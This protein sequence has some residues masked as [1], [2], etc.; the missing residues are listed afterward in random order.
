V[1][2]GVVEVFVELWVRWD[3]VLFPATPSLELQ[4]ALVLPKDVQAEFSFH[5]FPGS[6][7]DFS[8]AV[9]KSCVEK[10]VSR[11]W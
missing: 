5:N 1:G 8:S 2:V 3:S 7:S 9:E 11:L 4:L 6:W 10:L